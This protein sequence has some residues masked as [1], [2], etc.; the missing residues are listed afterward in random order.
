IAHRDGKDE[1][2]RA[3]PVEDTKNMLGQFAIRA[4][5][6]PPRAAERLA[7]EKLLKA[8]LRHRQIA[9]K[10]AAV[11]RVQADRAIAGP[12]QPPDLRFDRH[13]RQRIIRVEPVVAELAL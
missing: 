9:P 13:P 1:G 11:E 7:A 6:R 3:F 10:E 2:A 8:E 5:G 12:A 4:I